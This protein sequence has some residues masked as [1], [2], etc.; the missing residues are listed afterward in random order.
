[1]C[2][3]RAPK[4]RFSTL[5]R[6]QPLGEPIGSDRAARAVVQQEKVYLFLEHSIHKLFIQE[7]KTRAD[8]YRR[9][10]GRGHFLKC[11]VNDF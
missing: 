1:M 10:L 9:V 3:I 11:Q 4:E 6:M 7:G 8:A 5:M 2:R